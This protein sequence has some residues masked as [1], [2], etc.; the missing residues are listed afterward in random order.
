M[1]C[2]INENNEI[3]S[4]WTDESAPENAIDCDIGKTIH[5]T[6]SPENQTLLYK[7][8]DGKVTPTDAGIVWIAQEYARN[9]AT[10]FSTWQEQMD[11]QYWDQVNGT[12]TWKDAVAKVKSDNPKPDGWKE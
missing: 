2:T 3:T 8:V 12:T 5:G 7:L 11:Q 9:R 6:G 10:S 4:F 1:K